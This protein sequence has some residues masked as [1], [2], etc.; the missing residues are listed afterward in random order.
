MCPETAN[1]AERHV[2]LDTLIHMPGVP[3][4]MGAVLSLKGNDPKCLE[5]YTFRTEAWEGQ[6]EGLSIEEAV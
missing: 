6:H 1:A 5:V 2:G 4:G 3:N